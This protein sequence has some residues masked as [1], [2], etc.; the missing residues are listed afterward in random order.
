M[1][2]TMSK[3]GALRDC[4]WWARPE[5]RWVYSPPGPAA[6]FG[7]AVHAEIAAHV[8]GAAAE[9]T[10]D[11]AV[12]E[13]AE[14]V[15]TWWQN[16]REQ[17]DQWMAEPAYVLDIGRASARHV[18]N[19]IGR[20]Y[21]RL[22][23]LE[24]AGSADIVGLSRGVASVYDV[25][26]GRR[27]NVDPAAENAQLRTLA[28]AV[29]LAHG[30][31]RV[32]V[33]LVFPGPQGA[34]VDEHEYDALDLADWL[35]DLSDMAEAIPTSVPRPSK[36]ACRYCP[37]KASCPAMTSALAEVTPPR[38][39]P[40]VMDAGQFEGP[41]HARE[42]YLALRALK[43]GIDEA[44]AALRAYAAE[45][46]PVPLGDG[47][48]YGSRVSQRESIDLTT[49]AAVETLQRELGSTWEAAVELSTTKTRIKDAAR[50]IASL[51]GEKVTAV[52]RRVVDALRAVGAVKTSTSTTWDEINEGA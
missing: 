11:Q 14:S 37:A 30:V 22:G 4:Q 19:N 15:I 8:S 17:H 33:G 39:L 43:T 36:S 2:A 5:A 10:G 49:R 38:R 13:S 45:H 3:L 40:I 50:S 9:A 7:T 26:T 52:E 24:V 35:T 47:K 1:R 48:V 23:D 25:K 41:E 28:L 46:G 29:H 20:G 34:S 18:G 51:T 44:W 12:R 27:E 42:Q 16:G 32:R 31:D 6:E 21:P